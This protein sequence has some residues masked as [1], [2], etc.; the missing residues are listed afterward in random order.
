M[1]A[2]SRALAILR[3]LIAIPSV[4]PAYDPES[5]G[6][7][8]IATYIAAWARSLG[9]DV[10][11][12]SVFPGRDNVLVRLAPEDADA[13]NPPVLLLEAHTDTV[14]VDTM[15]DP[16][17]PSIRD[18]RL[19]GRGACDTKGSLAAMMA[20]VESLVAE[21][22]D[23][24]CV[25]ELL[26]AVDEETSGT[27]VRAHVEAGH[28]ADGAIVGE[29]TGLRV[30]HAHNGCIR[31]EIVVTGRAAHTSVAGEGINAIEGMAEV[32]VALRD[33]N[34]ELANR[35]GGV[36]ANGSLTVSHISGGTGINIVPEQCVISYDR[37]T[38][39]GEVAADVLAEIDAALGRVRSARPDLGI[40]RRVPALIDNAL[41]T[42]PDAGIVR[43]ASAA[44]L[45]L[46]LDPAPTTVP[47][48]SDASKLGVDAG[49]P[50]I[51]YGPGDIAQAHGAGEYVE[52]AQVEAAAAFYRAVALGFGRADI[53]SGGVV[54]H[55]AE[56]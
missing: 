33:L 20:A 14:S 46:G 37:R 5:A 29:P 16:F 11:R 31:G 3:D 8:L 30:I 2:S 38:V 7:S 53:V 41:D 4:N 34:A 49:V 21:R 42:A 23:L 17:T 1:T 36:A 47:Y 32:I 27:G 50:A 51:V 44:N 26:A 6:E 25:V 24:P 10:H 54:S 55:S 22:N 52:I 19:Y 9:L 48:G 13:G 28:R 35:A 56:N 12:Q 45:S 15:A 39:P 40:E 18:G 43:V